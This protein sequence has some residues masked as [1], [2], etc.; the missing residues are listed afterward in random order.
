MGATLHAIRVDSVG[1]VSDREKRATIVLPN[2]TSSLDDTTAE[3]RDASS[4]D[5]V[6]TC[7]VTGPMTDSTTGSTV[8]VA[9]FTP[10]AT[11]G[12]Y[13]IAVPG[14]MTSNGT[15]QSV[16]FP[17]A[18]DVFRPVL[19]HAML[20]LFGQ[21]CGTGV[22]IN[23]DNQHWAHGMCHGSDASQKFLDGVLMDTIKPSLR[24]WHDAGDYGK[25][26]TNGA[27]TVGMMLHAFERFPATLSTLKLPIPETGGAIPDYLDEVKWELDWLMTTMGDDGSVA[28]K[29]TAMNF[30]QPS[31]SASM[32]G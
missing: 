10:F 12:R 25:Y 29:V 22:E 20:G 17:I 7:T 28:F 21:R 6:A 31:S 23:V 26:T 5:V 19:V 9:D 13:Y 16:P 2:G 11:P 1:Y 24:G 8:Y 15:A 3:V 4:G 27:F 32:P 18:A 30:E 14:L